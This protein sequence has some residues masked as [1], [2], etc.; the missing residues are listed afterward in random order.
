MITFHTNC[1]PRM[2]QRIHKCC[3]HAFEI[4]HDKL[5]LTAEPDFYFFKTSQQPI[6]NETLTGFSQESGAIICRFFKV[7]FCD[8]EL[9][10]FLMHELNHIR[11]GQVFSIE[12]HP[13][14]FNWMLAEGLAV[15]FEQ[16]LGLKTTLLSPQ[17]DDSTLRAG[18]QQIITISDT[19]DWNHYDWFYNFDRQADLPIN[20]AYHIGRWLVTEFCVYYKIQPS[21]ALD[22][23]LTD[24][25]RFAEVLCA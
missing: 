25:L 6:G 13:T 3:Q 11:Q 5:K 14:L 8:Q 24:F 22:Y 4:V 23:Q 12:Q 7:N 15:T 1:T 10:A 16:E 20:F 2:Q 9:L 21:Q 18:L 17:P 19:N